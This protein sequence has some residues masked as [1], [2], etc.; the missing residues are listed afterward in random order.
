VST[1]ASV[2]LVLAAG[3]VNF[4]KEKARRS[5]GALLVKIVD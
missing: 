4:Q 1:D 3:A 2:R 5:S